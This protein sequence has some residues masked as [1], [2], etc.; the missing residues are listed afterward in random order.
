MTVGIRK[1]FAILVVL[2]GL[3][4]A[5]VVSAQSPDQLELWVTNQKAEGGLPPD[6]VLVY[7]VGQA[8]GKPILTPLRIFTGPATLL[9]FPTGILVTADKVYVANE[10][11]VTGTA[12]CVL[13]EGSTTSCGFITIYVRT[14]VENS[15]TLTGTPAPVG[16]TK[17]LA[18]RNTGLNY[19]FGIAI[20]NR[21][22][23]LYVA[24][25]T[26]TFGVLGAGS[27]NVYDVNALAAATGGVNA[28]I[29]P[30]RT[31]VG[32]EGPSYIVYDEVNAELFVANSVNGLVTVHRRNSNG[33]FIQV[34]SI[35]E[36]GAPDE[37]R[38]NP[39]QQ[40]SGLALAGD[41][42]F[43]AHG[44]VSP[45]RILVYRRTDS[46][47]PDPLRRIDAADTPTP[48]VKSLDDTTGLVVDLQRNLLFTGNDARTT[49]QGF[50]SV[51]D[52]TAQGAATPLLRYQES[53]G[54]TLFS[55]VGLALATRAQTPS[56]GG[57]YTVAKPA[58]QTVR[59]PAGA[60]IDVPVDLVFALNVS[61]TVTVQTTDVR[62]VSPSNATSPV[63]L[64]SVSPQTC[65]G[66]SCRITLT[67]SVSST[68]SLGSYGVTVATHGR[69]G[70]DPP[71]CVDHPT[72]FN[73][74]VSD[75][76]PLTGTLTVLKQGAGS[77]TVRSDKS[78]V[79]GQPI[80]CGPV[81][82]GDFRDVDSPIRL[83]ATPDNNESIFS[84]WSGCNSLTN[85]CDVPIV[86]GTTQR[87]TAQCDRLVH[88]ILRTDGTGSGTIDSNPRPLS[89]PDITCGSDCYV[90][91]SIVTLTA[92]PNS[93]SEFARW[94]GCE[95]STSAQCSVPL[96]DSKTVT[97]TF[98]RVF[99]PVSLT[100]G[101]ARFQDGQPGDGTGTISSDKAG[102]DGEQINCGPQCQE[103]TKQFAVGVTVTLTASASDSSF[104]G[105]TT[106][107]C[108]ASPTCPVMLNGA[109]RVEALFVKTP[110]E[111]LIARL[112]LHV[113]GVTPPSLTN[114]ASL[115]EALKPPVPTLTGSAL[116]S[117]FFDGPDF[118]QRF[119]DRLT[120]EDYLA[121]LFRAFLGGEAPKR[122]PDP[123][124]LRVDFFKALFGSLVA[125]LE[126]RR[127]RPDNEI[128]SAVYEA[129]LGTTPTPTQSAQFQPGHVV[130]ATLDI[131]SS[132]GYE[133]RR[134][135]PSAD[136]VFEDVR[137]LYQ[138]FL[139]RQLDRNSQEV[140]NIFRTPPGARNPTLQDARNSI[141]AVGRCRTEFRTEFVRLFQ[142]DT[143]GCQP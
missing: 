19:P 74:V 4:G 132:A 61:G 69:L 134:R 126:K 140:A 76:P 142:L 6:A 36:K 71:K 12:P 27:V 32:L 38:A 115:I 137:A 68:T 98:N 85:R 8:G 51:F 125:D 123:D 70:D 11:V 39:L 66:P 114:L 21:N 84:G 73:I 136:G 81:C 105:W 25:Q 58:D 40:V 67:F 45:A 29:A 15:C 109:T 63:I 46:G 42:L 60:A 119:R 75:S 86:L 131:L 99:P 95:P 37:T 91:N 43:V 50:I 124:R 49:S 143:L 96:T 120:P 128:A 55:P 97:A 129:L 135:A 102:V 59:R 141:E 93:G 94:T 82:S 17:V 101:K 31:I 139:G 18:G 54:S 9:N 138:A 35:R 130:D 13:T 108:G 83:T 7:D 34:R 111:G 121:V 116:V 44:G 88:L 24:N 20:N 62:V 106:F 52:R 90:V 16:P 113:S 87:V 117:A 22:G 41:E 26:R 14:Q 72:D 107:A 2:I 118:N 47:T 78:D 65:S 23:E 92:R 80:D 104:V 89:G 30:I 77:C 64:K 103:Q 5:S 112:Y 133:A 122:V 28:D 3:L 110:Q 127:T 100:V 53:P 10:P 48:G 79:H 56:S 57:D 1:T 33:E